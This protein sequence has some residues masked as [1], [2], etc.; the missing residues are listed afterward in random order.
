MENMKAK[1]KKHIENYYA[2]CER[3]RAEYAEYETK[4]AKNYYAPILIQ[5]KLNEKIRKKTDL[6]TNLFS[7][8]F[9]SFDF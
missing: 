7:C 6:Y 9:I 8:D 3:I 5:E 1:I 4:E 2:K